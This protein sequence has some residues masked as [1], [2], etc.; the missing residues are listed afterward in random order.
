MSTK[1]Q[2]CSVFGYAKDL[3]E[4]GAAT[5]PIISLIIRD[6]LAELVGDPNFTAT[7]AVAI[8]ENLSGELR[9]C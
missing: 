8:Y 1:N 4:G 5:S 3:I 2:L 9:C 6:A 7:A